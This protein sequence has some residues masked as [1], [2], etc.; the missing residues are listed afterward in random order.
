MIPAFPA[1]VT[2]VQ[3]FDTPA[4]VATAAIS[5]RSTL[6][7]QIDTIAGS[8]KAKT[9][10]TLG[11]VVWDLGTS[12]LV[13]RNAETPLPMASVFKLPLAFCAYQSIDR[14][15]LRLD[16]RVT[17]L[18]SDVVRGVSPIADAFPKVSGYSLRELLERMLVDSDNTAADALYRLL[19]GPDAI[20]G[21]LHDAGIDAMIVRTNEA[22]NAA[23]EKSGRSF[24]AA[25]TTPRPRQPLH[26]CS[27]IST[28]APRSRRHRAPR[29]SIP[30]RESIPARRDYE[31]VCRPKPGCCIKPERVGLSEPPSMRR[32][33]SELPS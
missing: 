23:A 25:A 14:G 3:V 22:G 28:V 29:C 12:V 11:V 26:C 6:E 24:P 8:A 1:G 20:N 10:G 19:G 21:S 9:G 17:I 2:M 4:P 32:T 7:A 33:T 18:P 13:Q 16:Q 30:W 31:R 15:K 27:R 5:E